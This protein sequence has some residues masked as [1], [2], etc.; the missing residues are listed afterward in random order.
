MQCPNCTA[1]TAPGQSICPQC[2]ADLIPPP[3]PAATS[4]TPRPI[5]FALIV[6]I[7]LC[8]IAL[9]AWSTFIS[10]RRDVAAE[11]LGY[12][13]GSLILPFLIAY[14]IA[15]AKR[16]RNGLWFALSFFALAILTSFSTLVGLN[17]KSLA[18]LPKAE[19][20][21]T[22][23][24]VRPLPSDASNDDKQTV[25]ATVAVF[26]DLRQLNENYTRKQAELAPEFPKLY[27]PEAFASRTA[28]EHCRS[29]VQQKLA[30]D[31]HSSKKLHQ[32]PQ[33]IQA[34]LQKST[35]SQKDQLDFLTSFQNQ[36]GSSDVMK[37]HEVMI[38]TEEKWAN[39]TTDLY[40][41]TLQ[42]LSQ[43]TAKK[44][45][46]VISSTAVKTQ[47][48]TRYAI[49]VKLRNDFNTS[50]RSFTETRTNYMNSQGIKPSN[51]GMKK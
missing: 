28:L 36:F 34:L 5:R 46:L 35:L 3:P 20:L 24:G 40:D 29:V 45:T 43:I 19:M 13:L 14:A 33:T 2:S 23:A 15:G 6:L 12:F 22:L 9:I 30:L 17:K 1:Q 10:Y 16:R 44:T 7:L 39:A 4:P 26:A 42:H 21:E 38:T 31:E 51:L 8:S 41:F 11:A 18:D 25:A 27:V 49:A 32:L 37:S 47:F 48:D 50:A